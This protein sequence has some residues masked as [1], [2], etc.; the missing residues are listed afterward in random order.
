MVLHDQLYGWVDLWSLGFAHDLWPIY[1]HLVICSKV[2]PIDYWLHNG[3]PMH[4]FSAFLQRIFILLFLEYIWF[5]L[6]DCPFFEK[7]G[8]MN[9][10][11]LILIFRGEKK[12]LWSKNTKWRIMF[13][14][15]KTVM[16]ISLSNYRI[17]TL[18][19][20]QIIVWYITD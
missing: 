14:S 11:L 8:T 18:D 9:Y 13:L 7:T 4:A 20:K 1:L 3:F 10:N 2:F 19:E 17:L 5:A 12:R 6:W 15:V 16:I